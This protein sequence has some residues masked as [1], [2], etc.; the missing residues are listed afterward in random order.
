MAKILKPDNAG[1]STQRANEQAEQQAREVSDGDRVHARSA[2]QE[3][4]DLEEK[5]V[6]EKR[7]RRDTTADH[8]RT[9]DPRGKLPRVPPTPSGP[10]RSE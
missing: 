3:R 4:R 8:A 7:D 9:M 10:I 1:E 5:Q 2:A 6:Q